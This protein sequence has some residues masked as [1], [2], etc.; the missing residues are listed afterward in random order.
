MRFQGFNPIEHIRVAPR[1]A[2]PRPRFRTTHERISLRQQRRR[3]RDA[4]RFAEPLSFDQHAGQARMHR[5]PCHR[6]ADLGDRPVLGRSQSP[7]QF[8]RLLDRI[9][10]RRLQPGKGSHLRFAERQE[11]Q[12]GPGQIDTA[13]LRQRL[14]RA[15]GVRRRAPQANADA[16]PRSA[17][18]S[19]ALVGGVLGDRH[20]FQSVHADARIE[21]L[22]SGQ[23]GIDDGRHALDGHRGLRDISRQHNPSLSLRL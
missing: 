9:L 16:G 22:H 7:Q 14:L 20:Q 19:G 21:E 2:F 1:P 5:Q 12:N 6:P 4:R 13:D 10:T 17:S 11:L 3:Q 23:A 8:H 15:L 18:S